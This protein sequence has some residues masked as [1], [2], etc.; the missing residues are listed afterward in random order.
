[1]LRAPDGRRIPVSVNGSVLRDRN[2][3]LDGVVFVAHDLR[4]ARR[5]LAE[6]M[7]LAEEARVTAR[8]A[9]T[10]A[11]AL[12]KAH[13]ELREVQGKLVQSAKMSAVGRLAGGVAH[14]IRS[15]LAMMAS[16]VEFILSTGLEDK[17]MATE[18]LERILV[19]CARAESVIGNV[20]DFARTPGAE[21][22]PIDVNEVARAVAGLM[23]ASLV[24]GGRRR[25]P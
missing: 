5:K 7:A 23:R 15:P 8:D 19:E 12:E 13:R 3:N 11:M 10:R 14:E 21:S 2:G 1:M 24:K 9:E 17:E 20:L 25:V 22:T 6:A 18:G 16:T 4:D